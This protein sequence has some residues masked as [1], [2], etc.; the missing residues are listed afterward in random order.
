MSEPEKKSNTIGFKSRGSTAS[1][2]LRA[3][4][5]DGTASELFLV[6]GMTIG[7]TNANS[8]QACDDGSGVVERSHA[9]VGFQDDGSVVLK[10][11]HESAGV[12]TSGSTVS[13]L[14]LE[15]GSL[16]RIGQ[17]QFEV[18]GN[19]ETGQG[20]ATS[21]GRG[22]P[23]CGNADVP[24]EHVVATRCSACGQALVMVPAETNCG[25]PVF[26]PGVFRD[27]EGK[28][29][30]ADKFVARG[31]MGYVLKGNADQDGA[32]AIKVLIFD[33]NTNDQ[34]VSRFKQE[35]DLLR[36]VHDPNVLRF[37]SHGQ[38]AGLCFLVMEWVDGHDLRSELPRP[39]RPETLVSY[40]KARGWFQQACEGLNAIHRQGVVHRDIKPSNL[41][42]RD[43]GKLLVADLG[44]A[45]Q[46]DDGETGMTRTGQL[47]GTYFYMAPEQHSAPDLVD[48][49]TDIYSL[50][51]TFWEILTGVK[52]NSVGLQPPSAVNR[53]VPKAFDEV[54]LKMLERNIEDRPAS[55]LEVLRELDV[56]DSEPHKEPVQLKPRQEGAD[57]IDRI[58][59]FLRQA[60]T[61]VKGWLAY[62]RPRIRQLVT[63][64]ANAIAAQWRIWAVELKALTTKQITAEAPGVP[65][66]AT[67]E[68]SS[69]P[70]NYEDEAEKGSRIADYVARKRY[71]VSRAAEQAKAR[72]EILWHVN[73]ALT[74]PDGSD[75]Q[76]D[77]FEAAEAARTR[78]P[79]EIR[80]PEFN[81]IIER[82]FEEA[83]GKRRAA[84]RE[85]E[86]EKV[87]N[88]LRE[89]VDAA[90]ALPE[91]SDAK[92]DALIRVRGNLAL[93]P[94]ALL[95]PQLAETVTQDFQV[96]I[97]KRLV[98][99]LRGRGD[100]AFAA[101]RNGLALSSYQ[102]LRRLSLAD[103]W[104]TARI[105]QILTLRSDGFLR[106]I[107]TMQ[108]GQLKHAREQL[109]RLQADFIGDTAFVSECEQ[110][111]ARIQLVEQ[112]VRETIPT[113][114]AN[115]SFFRM[116]A[117]LQEIAAENISV[118]GLGEILSKIRSILA[119]ESQKLDLARV[120][121]SRGSIDAARELIAN[122]R[123]AIS[124]HPDADELSE[125]ADAEELRQSRLVHE[126][127]DLASKGRFLSVLCRLEDK[128]SGS[129]A[130]LGL[131]DVFRNAAAHRRRSNRFL[132]MVA[133]VAVGTVAVVAAS[134]C[135]DRV[136]CRVEGLLKDMPVISSLGDQARAL[137]Y[138]SFTVFVVSAY[139]LL[140]LLRAVLKGNVRAG[141]V[142]SAIAS[143]LIV[144]GLLCC[145]DVGERVLARAFS[146]NQNPGGMPMPAAVVLS[147]DLIEGTAGIVRGI[148]VV[149]V[150][151]CAIWGMSRLGVEAVV[152]Q[153]I[154]PIKFAVCSAL[155]LMVAKY[156]ADRLSGGS[157][158]HGLYH[159]ICPSALCAMAVVAIAVPV[160]ARV[161]V[162]ALVVV[163]VVG[164]CVVWL[165][166]ATEVPPA[167]W[168]SL[169]T[170][171]WVAVLALACLLSVQRAGRKEMLACMA[172]AIMSVTLVLW[173]LSDRSGVI[174]L[175][176]LL[177]WGC[178]C[179]VLLLVC[180]KHILRKPYML[181]RFQTGTYFRQTPEAG[182]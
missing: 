89:Q 108:N 159:A 155:A 44:V 141:L 158:F 174:L 117:I 4:Q 123:E 137:G 119:K 41:L 151:S 13:S 8:I 52:P 86:V 103:E 114:K 45:K 62:A 16:F 1:W 5:P 83:I 32:V 129:L 72:E 157:A 36:R 64:I 76:L 31:G 104:V 152:P 9:R 116:A 66:G 175:Q 132:L 126:V 49:R 65:S 164:L 68:T 102:E 26:L 33:G 92:L 30:A 98:A 95:T 7:R 127:T 38:E 2:K 79:A 20:S 47:P 173:Q 112:R 97:E 153:A 136:L 176:R 22:C 133:W 37:V 179:M 24:K 94:H 75:E 178:A 14:R 177:P 90:L 87:R 80:T 144:I 78:L 46:L 182:E 61:R 12:E 140:F 107:A 21:S 73:A 110:R 58:S 145:V 160:K 109:L 142:V 59:A 148:G 166:S 51:F 88:E 34:A 96:V 162:G 100:E 125:L 56:P 147:T 170:F 139:L 18:V 124:D 106:A 172:A 120:Y 60:D 6:D 28:Q 156:A 10:C 105:D 69:E 171:L 84:L 167:S 91:G 149:T 48:Q 131:E 43:D 23:Y 71:S 74:L 150:I 130:K 111:L 15:I 17:T 19:E 54:L 70:Q 55:I 57:Y 165:L 53:S 118:A 113:L 181:E 128:P 77:A 122:V 50:G 134:M 154:P 42:L 143:H 27:G 99:A 82:D 81:R 121:I 85:A 29:F 146:Q 40:A 3:T 180:Q 169:G 35:I 63:G 138:I 39:G 11:L 93:M 161:L 67:K 101:K 115:K 135:S 168:N 163:T 25:R